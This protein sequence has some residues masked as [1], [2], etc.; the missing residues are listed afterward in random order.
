M[1]LYNLA[2]RGADD[3]RAV[4]VG[5]AAGDV[6]TPDLG[7]AMADILRFIRDHPSE[8]DF[9]IYLAGNGASVPEAGSPSLSKVLHITD[10]DGYTFD[11]SISYSSAVQKSIADDL[12]GQASA[13]IG[14]SETVTVTNT[15]PGRNLAFTAYTGLVNN[16]G[17][18]ALFLEAVWKSGNPVCVAAGQPNTACGVTISTARL[19]SSIDAGGA[20]DLT[21]Y[22][23]LPNGNG[24]AG[25]A[26][27]PESAW[28]GIASQLSSPDDYYVF[29]YG[30]DATRFLTIFPSCAP[31]ASSGLSVGPVIWSLSG[32]C[33][34]TASLKQPSP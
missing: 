1:K 15:T 26:A 18:P 10:S 24:A 3:V 13:L 9:D 11:I 22:N 5:C 21:V 23:G 17:D 19:P 25:I 4:T 20:A 12:P 27:L 14:F 34:P 2:Q 7:T 30:K 29:Y 32:S 28:D 16:L 33:V 6:D 31:I 8:A